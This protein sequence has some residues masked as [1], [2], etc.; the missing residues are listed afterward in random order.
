MLTVLALALCVPWLGASPAA[1]PMTAVPLARLMGHTWFE[2]ASFA[3]VTDTFGTPD[4]TGALP[5]RRTV[6]GSGVPVA[7]HQD[8]KAR[9]H[10]DRLLVFLGD[11][12]APSRSWSWDAAA[13]VFL[14]DSWGRRLVPGAA[15]DSAEH[16]PFPALSA[17]GLHDDAA[18]V[19]TLKRPEAWLRRE[20]LL[21]LARHRVEQQATPRCRELLPFLD[22]P[23]P[24]LR[25]AACFAAGQC[26]EPDALPGLQRDVSD[27]DPEVRRAAQEALRILAPPSARTPP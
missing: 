15:A 23:L 8:G 17:R 5:L 18:F 2:T 9:L 19:A 24:E 25:A 12:A 21:A 11:E 27:P 14:G 1:A 16:D 20:A 13:G 3:G 6:L 22:D 10:G 4:A 26:R 7:G